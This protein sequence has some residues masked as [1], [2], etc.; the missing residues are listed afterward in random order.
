MEQ[1]VE[2]VGEGGG[3]LA[4]LDGSAETEHL[5]AQHPVHAQGVTV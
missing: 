3:H 5:T 4:A 2:G 1:E